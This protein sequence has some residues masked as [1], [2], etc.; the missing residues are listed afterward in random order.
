MSKEIVIALIS[1]TGVVLS[2]LISF[3]TSSRLTR[4][5][6]EKLRS[7]VKKTYADRLL[8][9]R[10]ET[11]PG[12]YY[13]ASNFLKE[14][15]YGSVDNLLLNEFR[16]QLIEWDSKN[17]IFLSSYAS[18]KLYSLRRRLVRELKQLTDEELKDQ[19][20]LKDLQKQVERL[21][22]ALR[23]DIGVYV[24]E[25]SDPDVRFSSFE[26]IPREPPKR[27]RKLFTRVP[28]V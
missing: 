25:F 6:L 20:L 7:E 17:A 21:E 5:E 28:R 11:Y 8:S 13:L 12:L 27:N 3:L 10:L 2:V 1:F 19:D 26:E 24:V 22:V 16:T 23:N 9:K 18:R 4:T 15:Q 14:I